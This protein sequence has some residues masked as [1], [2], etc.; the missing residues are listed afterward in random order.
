M[1]QK[2]KLSNQKGFTLIE[3]MIVI[4]I[5]GIL[6]AIAIPNFLSYRQKGQDSA[7][8]SEARNFYTAV[9]AEAAD[10][11]T[12]DSWGD[13]SPPV[14]FSQNP[15]VTYGS[16]SIDYDATTGVTSGT[17][18]FTHANGGTTYTLTGSTG[19]VSGS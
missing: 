16:G 19:L 17:L 4:A 8:E 11:G 18:T 5:I 15:D 1:L 12:S 6:A 2:V 13:G 10:V 14:G 7:A 3:L 9:M